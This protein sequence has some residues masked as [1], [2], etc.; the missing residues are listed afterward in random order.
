MSHRISITYVACLLLTCFSLMVA[1]SETVYDSCVTFDGAV[2]FDNGTSSLCD[3]HTSN[4]TFCWQT[5]TVENVTDAICKDYASCHQKPCAYGGE[6]QDDGSC[7][8]PRG[9]AGHHCDELTTEACALDLCQHDATCGY[10]LDHNVVCKC[11]YGYGGLLCE[12]ETD[13]T[14]LGYALAY[15]I[16]A[17]AFG[18]LTLLV[19]IACVVVRKWAKKRAQQ[20]REHYEDIP[21]SITSIITESKA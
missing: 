12:Q 20:A 11:P 17:G 21:K 16:A 5:I 10:D 4:G 1:S 19:I 18:G 15:K 3:V 8:C 6:C 7:T 13:W 2:T 9:L 14:Y